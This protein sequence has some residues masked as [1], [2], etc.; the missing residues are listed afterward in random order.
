MGDVARRERFKGGGEDVLGCIAFTVKNEK[1]P[2]LPRQG[3]AG[4][5]RVQGGDQVFVIHVN[6]VM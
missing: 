5:R 2:T 1:R 4:E 6:E 3:K